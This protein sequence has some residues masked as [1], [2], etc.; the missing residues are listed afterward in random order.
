MTRARLWLAP[1]L[2]IAAVV[3][4]AGGFAASSSAQEPGS[5]ELTIVVMTTRFETRLLRNCDLFFNN[6]SGTAGGDASQDGPARGA[7]SLARRSGETYLKRHSW[8]V[9]RF[10]LPGERKIT[11]STSFT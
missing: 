2:V 5:S 10:R 6:G 1:T 4:G 11:R 8:Q 7:F 3:I 9:E